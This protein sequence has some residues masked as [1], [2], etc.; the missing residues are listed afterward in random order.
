[1][2]DGQ[3]QATSVPQDVKDRGEILTR[4]ELGL[5]FIQHFALVDERRMGLPEIVQLIGIL[6]RL[7]YPGM[8]NSLRKEIDRRIAQAC[9]DKLDKGGAP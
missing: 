8:A 3:G 5:F 9:N 2:S 6:T 4:G 7:G 1:M